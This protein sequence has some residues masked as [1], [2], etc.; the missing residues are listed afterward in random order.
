MPEKNWI[1]RKPNSTAKDLKMIDKLLTIIGS[2]SDVR[3]KKSRSLA[4][5]NGLSKADRDR[6]YWDWA[7]P[8]NLE[9]VNLVEKTI[10]PWITKHTTLF[11][12]EFIDNINNILRWCKSDRTSSVFEIPRILREIRAYIVEQENKTKT[13]SSTSKDLKAMR[14]LLDKINSFTKERQDKWGS[15]IAPFNEKND[16]Y[17]RW[18]NPLNDEMLDRGEKL[19]LPWIEKHTTL[20]NVQFIDEVK[21]LLSQAREI[22]TGSVFELPRALRKIIAYIE[23]KDKIASSPNKDSRIIDKFLGQVEEFIRKHHEKWK[24]LQHLP[25]QEK[26]NA[27]IE[28]RTPL[29]KTIIDE[30]MAFIEPWCEKHTTLFSSQEHP[31]YA[32]P[33]SVFWKEVIDKIK[34]NPEDSYSCAN[35]ICLL[36]DMKEYIRDSEEATGQSKTSSLSKD[37]IKVNRL[38]GILEKDYWAVSTYPKEKEDS[39]REVEKT[40]K[41]VLDFAKPWCEKHT[42]LLNTNIT[43]NNETDRLTW[44]HGIYWDKIIRELESR[45]GDRLYHCMQLLGDIKRYIIDETAKVKTSG[46]LSKDLPYAIKLEEKIRSCLRDLRIAKN[47]ADEKDVSEK[48]KKVKDCLLEAKSFIEP[49][50]ENHV[51]LFNSSYELKDADCMLPHGVF[52][53]SILPYVKNEEEDRSGEIAHR[54]LSL[55]SDIETYL[56]K[57]TNT[58]NPYAEDGKWEIELGEKISSDKTGSLAKDLNK[59]VR[60]RKQISLH[61]Y[62]GDYNIKDTGDLVNRIL[63]FVEPWCEKH[64]DLFNTSCEIKDPGIRHP[65]GVY[66]DRQIR[67]IKKQEG[68]IELRLVSIRNL[69]D[70]IILYISRCKKSSSKIG[71]LAKDLAYVEKLHDKLENFYDLDDNEKVDALVPEAISFI[72]T[73]V[74]K[75]LDLLNTSYEIKDPGLQYPHGVWWTTVLDK[76]NSSEWGVSEV[77]DCLYD[78]AEYIHKEKFKSPRNDKGIELG[79]KISS[80]DPTQNPNFKSWFGASKVVDYN[81]RP[82]VVFHGTTHNFEKFDPSRGNIENFYGK[83]F[84]F[85]DSGEDASTNYGTKKSPDLISRIERRAEELVDNDDYE[86]YEEAYKKAEEELVGPHE[87]MVYLTYLKILKPVIVEKKGGTWFEI[88]FNEKTGKEF[89]SGVR[90]YNAFLKAAEEIGEDGVALWSKAKLYDDFT[91]YEFEKKIRESDE[92]GEVQIGGLIS[93][94]YQLMGFDG[95]IQIGADAQFNMKMPRGTTHYIVWKPNQIKSALGNR[96]TFNPMSPRIIASG[97]NRVKSVLKKMRIKILRMKESPNFFSLDTW[98]FN[99]EYINPILFELID[100]LTKEIVPW[101]DSL[102]N[103]LAKDEDTLQS[104]QNLKKICSEI[105]RYA[106]I[107]KVDNN[108]AGYLTRELGWIIDRSLSLLG[109]NNQ[110]QSHALGTSLP[111]WISKVAKEEDKT[112]VTPVPTEKRVK[113]L[114]SKCTSLT[115]RIDFLYSKEVTFFGD[116]YYRKVNPLIFSACEYIEEVQKWFDTCLAFSRDEKNDAKLLKDQY[117]IVRRWCNTQKEGGRNSQTFSMAIRTYI[118]TAL[119]YL[120]TPQKTATSIKTKKIGSKSLTLKKLIRY[121]KQLDK[122]CRNGDDTYDKYVNATMGSEEENQAAVDYQKEVAP[123]FLAIGKE[124][125]SCVLGSDKLN[126]SLFTSIPNTIYELTTNVTY[127]IKK[128]ENK[129]ELSRRTLGDV[130]TLDIKMCS[131]IENLIY[132]CDELGI[133]KTGYTKFVVCNFC[134][135][136]SLRECAIALDFLNTIKTSSFKKSVKL[137]DSVGFNSNEI[138]AD[139]KAEWERVTPSYELGKMGNLTI[140]DK[141]L[142]TDIYI[143]A[144]KEKEIVAIVTFKTLDSPECVQVDRAGVSSVG[145]N[146]NLIPQLYVWLLK[147]KVFQSITSSNIQ[148]PGGRSIWITLAKVPGINVFA[149]DSKN[150]KPFSIDQK[151]ID[152]DEIWDEGI[153]D[154]IDSLTYGLGYEKEQ[155]KEN[156]NLAPLYTEMH[157]IKN[158]VVLVAQLDDQAKLKFSYTVPKKYKQA[159]IKITEKCPPQGEY[160]CSFEKWVGSWTIT[161]QCE[162]TIY[163]EKKFVDGCIKHNITKEISRAIR[164]EYYECKKAV[165]LARIKYPKESP[166]IAA[167]QHIELGGEAHFLTVKECDKMSLEQYD[168]LFDSICDKLDWHSNSKISSKDYTCHLDI[169]DSHKGELQGKVTAY[170]K[171]SPVGYVKFSEAGN[172]YAP[173]LKDGDT[174]PHSVWIQHVFVAP[175]HR[176]KGIGTMMY[177]E[178]AKEF[179]GEPIVSSGTTEEGGKLRHSLLDKGVIKE[180]S[181][182]LGLVKPGKKKKVKSLEEDTELYAL[183]RSDPRQVS[184]FGPEH[185]AELQEMY[186][187][188]DTK[189][190]ESPLLKEGTK[191]SSGSSRKYYH[192]SRSD[193]SDLIEEKGL[194]PSQMKEHSVSDGGIYLFSSLDN[195]TQWVEEEML[196]FVGLTDIWEVTVP[197]DIVVLKDEHEDLRGW[198]SY[199][200]Y[201]P[202]SPENLKHLVRMKPISNPLVENNHDI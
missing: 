179:P 90:L 146:S 174:V 17:W 154:T 76:I 193:N 165:E 42:N 170:Y 134:K 202:I 74:E 120:E 49:W 10:R 43:I 18:A 201:D 121:K 103:F 20:F 72:K 9:M 31:D 86:A 99:Y 155:K 108:Y 55:L 194:L 26:E 92:S 113:K 39:L 123:K 160:I 80:G 7:V 143:A 164:H 66:W 60:F 168:D 166:Y 114:L 50:I 46:S 89:G 132:N 1:S 56:Y 12:T 71:N 190:F 77:L 125:V 105:I 95:I 22:D 13:S 122:I 64:I 137:T 124:L 6:I 59:I 178:L 156:K 140:I 133:P 186:K 195:A 191:A 78:I 44:P 68:E 111:T 34:K 136:K 11:N 116:D 101:V 73:W 169:V 62:S 21:K 79:E 161:P 110:K 96:G 30:A 196:P 88:R 51:D 69:L 180:S 81:G 84:Y 15:I 67:E 151:D 57:E 29:N 2:N 177:R 19:I 153:N 172:P 23:E 167:E 147:Q 106:G 5:D 129:K 3:E 37:L 159:V 188:P 47:N 141:K 45:E 35:L 75:H 162:I 197:E 33:H 171:E 87:G 144:M 98:R 173:E 182:K 36:E 158:D 107:H 70:D 157:N 152:E 139:L 118:K 32:L 91:A 138:F 63:E 100:T 40:V 149:W 148:S 131:L 181:S 65:H 28:W 53:E 176:R 14:N 41:D 119:H 83:G 94:A 58:P 130:V 184:L 85:T 104:C 142:S 97:E 117:I 27:L 127:L 200:V 128:V 16:I 135:G 112:W 198:G 192:C 199:V 52:W 150:K 25:P 126:P 163:L 189:K 4:N 187:K 8:N 109:E 102:P 185:E 61:P 93:R 115:D 38:L 82:K 48:S 24:E 183:V 145:S 54:I 175:G